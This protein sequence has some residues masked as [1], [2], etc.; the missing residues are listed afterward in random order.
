MSDSVIQIKSIFAFHG[1]NS[2]NWFSIL[3]SGL[4]Y[5]EVKNGRAYGNGIYMSLALAYSLYYAQGACTNW[6]NSALKMG[7]ILT[8]NEVVNRPAEFRSCSPHLVVQHASWV[9]KS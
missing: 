2:V 1:S 9:L 3:T 8:L 5:D 4:N 6:K 7:Q